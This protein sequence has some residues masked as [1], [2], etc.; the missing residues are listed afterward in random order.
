MKNRLAIM[1][2]LSCGMFANAT[3]TMAQ[4][5]DI[6]TTYSII[7]G[8]CGQGTDQTIKV[9]QGRVVGPGFDCQ[10]S[11]PTSAGTGLEA[12]LASCTV[13][14]SDQK[15]MLIFDLGNNPDHFSVAVPGVEN[16]IDMY[17]C[18]KVP[19]LD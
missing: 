9:S 13:N 11:S 19:G 2:L 12:Y 8:A 3:V 1:T 16:W 15:D 5:T 18:T 6:Q 14:G 7:K 10:I 4:G 17:P